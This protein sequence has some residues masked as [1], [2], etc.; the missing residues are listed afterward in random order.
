MPAKSAIS[1]IR[2]YS[3]ATW[4]LFVTINLRPAVLRYDLFYACLF[5][6]GLEYDDCGGV[7]TAIPTATIRNR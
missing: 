7:Q 1:V 5:I 3:N 4:P 6:P 2:P